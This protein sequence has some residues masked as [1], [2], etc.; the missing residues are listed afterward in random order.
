LNNLSYLMIGLKAAKKL[1]DCLNNLLYSKIGLKEATKLIDYRNN[2]I[3]P[4]KDN[5]LKVATK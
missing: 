1:V 2:L 3:L 5:H 4:R